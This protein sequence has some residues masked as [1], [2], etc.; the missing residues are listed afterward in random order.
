TSVQQ[1]PSFWID[2][3]KKNAIRKSNE[4]IAIFYG[5]CFG[6]CYAAQHDRPIGDRP[7]TFDARPGGYVEGDGG[8]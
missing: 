6:E 1:K 3:S 2:L 7:Y 8:G 5:T 4:P